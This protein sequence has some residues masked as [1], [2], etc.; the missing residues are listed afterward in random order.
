MT[1]LNEIQLKLSAEHFVISIDRMGDPECVALVQLVN[2]PVTPYA[3][4]RC[5][6]QGFA[7][8]GDYLST[9][10]LEAARAAFKKRSDELR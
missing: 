4:Y 10:D 6:P 5:N 7:Y 8:W 1:Y 3:T 9:T 2:N